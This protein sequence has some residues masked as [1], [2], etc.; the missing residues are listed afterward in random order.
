MHAKHHPK[1]GGGD[2]V[3]EEKEEKTEAEEAMEYIGGRGGR[4]RETGTE[5]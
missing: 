2:G 3:G 1:E 4:E 5:M